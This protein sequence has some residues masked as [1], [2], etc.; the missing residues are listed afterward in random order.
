MRLQYIQNA[1]QENRF[2]ITSH[3]QQKMLDLCITFNDIE[4]SLT[5]GEVIETKP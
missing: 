1:I 4:F 5:I 2:K 3:A